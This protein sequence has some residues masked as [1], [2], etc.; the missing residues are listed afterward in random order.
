MAEISKNLKVILAD[1]DQD[2]REFFVHAAQRFS[3]KLSVVTLN[4]GKRVLEYLAELDEHEQY[5]FLLDINMPKVSGIECLSYI[6]KSEKWNNVPVV[7]YST[8]SSDQ[9]IQRSFSEGAN[10]YV[11]KPFS[12]SSLESIINKLILS[13]FST[14]PS[15][16][17]GFVIR[18]KR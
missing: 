3:D 15:S 14:K 12:L 5:L 18:D 16:M 2:D 11:I 1:D 4:D 7:M 13:D 6:R 17:D 9:D 8:S 10:S